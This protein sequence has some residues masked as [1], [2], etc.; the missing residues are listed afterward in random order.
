MRHPRVEY[1]EITGWPAAVS[2]RLRRAISQYARRYPCF[3]VGVTNNPETRFALYRNAAEYEGGLYGRMIVLYATSSAENVA[4]MEKDLVDYFLESPGNRNVNLGGAGPFRSGRPPYYLYV[5]LMEECYHSW[6]PG[7][8]VQE[9]CYW[10]WER[11]RMF[12]LQ[13][14]VWVSQGVV[15]SALEDITAEGV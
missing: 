5:V 10:C 11:R 13:P 2:S 14:N 9:M 12:Q 6:G 15:E 8:T 3:K 4:A 1:R 7:G